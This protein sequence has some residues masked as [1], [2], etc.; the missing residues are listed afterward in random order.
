MPPPR[1]PAW[2]VSAPVRAM[3]AADRRAAAGVPTVI[4]HRNSL[5]RPRPLSHPA[6]PGYGPAGSL[7]CSGPIPVMISGTG[8]P[9]RPDRTGPP[10]S[11]FLPG[12]AGAH[13]SRT[14]RDDVRA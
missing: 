2:Q 7:Q 5:W 3:A 8:T 6:E 13:A 11:D 10:G 14:L 4:I 12:P 9:A 1:Q